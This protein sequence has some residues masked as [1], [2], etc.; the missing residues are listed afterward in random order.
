MSNLF[1]PDNTPIQQE[2]EE[3][4][5]QLYK[6]EESP[7]TGETKYIP[8]QVKESELTEAQKK[9]LCQMLIQSFMHMPDEVQDM[10]MNWQDAMMAHGKMLHDAAEAAKNGNVSPLIKAQA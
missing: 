2:P 8:Y 7:I 9:A 10:F 1:N 6:A 3:R 4:V 5:Y